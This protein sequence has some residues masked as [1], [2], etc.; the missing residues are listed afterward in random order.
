MADVLGTARGI[1]LIHWHDGDLRVVPDS[2]RR[3]VEVAFENPVEYGVSI[4]RDAPDGTPIAIEDAIEQIEPG[5]P[6]HAA[7][8]ILSLPG[9]FLLEG[10][11]F[12]PGG[13][14]DEAVEALTVTEAV[15]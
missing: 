8:A 14:P 9:G 7:R 6:E 4:D 2:E 5:S 12:I 11:E 3:R 1:D 10:D 13:E 15:T